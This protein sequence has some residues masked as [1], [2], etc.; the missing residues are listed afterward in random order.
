[1][2]D[3]VLVIPELSISARFDRTISGEYFVLSMSGQQAILQ[4]QLE[5]IRLNPHPHI[6]LIEKRHV[7]DRL[8]L[9]YLVKDYISLES[10]LARGIKANNV[11][12]I[13]E[14]IVRIIIDSK[15]YFLYNHCFLLDTRY[16][17]IDPETELIALVYLPVK[18]SE[19]INIC[20]K[21]FLKQF[22]RKISLVNNSSEGLHFLKSIE[23]Y[24]DMHEVSLIG[25]QGLIK[26]L[27][28]SFNSGILRQRQAKE[29]EKPFHLN[30]KIK[31]NQNKNEN[32]KDTVSDKE[33]TNTCSKKTLLLYLILQ[34]L[35]V[36]VLTGFLRRIESLEYPLGVFGLIIVLL[37]VGD[38]FVINRMFPKNNR[39]ETEHHSNILKR[40][41][42]KKHIDIKL[43]RENS[44]LKQEI[45][46][47]KI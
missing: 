42:W 35:F 14:A 10:Y 5:M 38:V 36:M 2:E 33:K 24:Q 3:G 20:L 27:R 30:M 41:A 25:I 18:L 43:A 12:K 6:L 4:Y 17:F 47:K 15:N 19:D 7:D 21:K 13:L 23:D 37:T 22:I 46:R 32:V 45:Y 11:L 9:C 29:L 34:I 31:E 26:D 44:I 39:R 16:I 40:E 28:V 8:E 1:M